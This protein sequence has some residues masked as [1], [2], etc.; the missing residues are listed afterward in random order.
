MKNVLKLIAV[1]AFLFA[2]VLSW[3]CFGNSEV[4]AQKSGAAPL[5]KKNCASC[6]GNDGQS[7]SFRGKLVKAQNLTDSA[8][9]ADVSDEHIFNAISNG[10]K[11][12]PAFGK[13][14]S[15]Q[16]MNSLVAYVR[17]LKK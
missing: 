6:H 8:W 16:E 5:Y 7:K 1:F 11:K 15:E 10:R 9:Q 17:G 13:K 12:M 2:C 4:S 14:L 3:L